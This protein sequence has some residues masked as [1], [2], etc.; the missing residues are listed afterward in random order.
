MRRASKDCIK[1]YRK[2][3]EFQLLLEPQLTKGK[4][5]KLSISISKDKIMTVR[6][7]EI[8]QNASLSRNRSSDGLP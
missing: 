1:I 5:E 6:H 8:V 2:R 7:L 4:K 3:P